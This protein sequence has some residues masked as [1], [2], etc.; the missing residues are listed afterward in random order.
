MKCFMSRR[1]ASLTWTILLMTVAWL[2]PL[3]RSQSVAPKRRAELVE[4]LKT[5]QSDNAEISNKARKE[6][7]R[8][9]DKTFPALLEI[10][11]GGKG[12]DER[13]AAAE[14]LVENDPKNEAVVPPLV[15]ISKGRKGFSSEEDLLCRRGATFLLAF[16]TTGIRAL[17]E[18]LKDKDLFVRRSA[19]FAFDELTET[20][21]YPDGSLQAMK[22]A[23]PVIAQAAEEKDKIVSEMSQ[24]VLAQISRSDIEV[25]SSEAKRLIK[26]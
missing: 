24:E 3:C 8:D 22:E 18:L 25:L 5:Y 19:I 9:R 23:I 14:F 17:T 20:S 7:L 4:L 12:C 26:Q 21:N 13:K 6:L 15:E 2:T 10:L 1:R 16:S 11:K